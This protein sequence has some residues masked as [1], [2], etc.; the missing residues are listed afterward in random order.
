[1][2]CHA[3]HVYRTTGIGSRFGT[4]GNTVTIT[5]GTSIDTCQ[6]NALQSIRHS[7]KGDTHF[8]KRRGYRRGFNKLLASATYD[9]QSQQSACPGTSHF[10][11]C[12]IYTN[13]S[14]GNKFCSSHACRIYNDESYRLFLLYLIE[15]YR[16]GNCTQY[17]SGGYKRIT[18]DVRVYEIAQIIERGSNVGYTSATG[19]SIIDA[20]SI[21]GGRHQLQTGICDTGAVATGTGT[22]PESIINAE[23][24][25]IEVEQT[26]RPQFNGIKFLIGVYTYTYFIPAV[27]YQPG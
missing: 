20:G 22:L 21:S 17:I 12:V 24:V 10:H 19:G 16:Y 3:D 4:I 13:C 14:P 26:A 11:T 9:V 18:V 15:L 27:A 25:E 23:S 5:V 1:M 7:G 2:L 8:I 6:L